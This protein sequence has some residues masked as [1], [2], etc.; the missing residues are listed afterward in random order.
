M[1]KLPREELQFYPR[2]DYGTIL[3]LLQGSCSDE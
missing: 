3:V 1:V 2:P